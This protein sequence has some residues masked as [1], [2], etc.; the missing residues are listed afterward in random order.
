MKID[1]SKDLYA[2]LQV[3]PD[4]ERAAIKAAYRRLS[5]LHH[6]NLSS[7]HSAVRRWQEIDNAYAVLSNPALRSRYDLLRGAFYGPLARVSED[8]AA[9]RPQ[10]SVDTASPEPA[11]APPV[12]GLRS[13]LRRLG[14]LAWG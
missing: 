2:I 4:S 7:S 3:S 1:I 13:L 6:S 10:P 8:S 5:K 11:A 9:G 14:P 12:R